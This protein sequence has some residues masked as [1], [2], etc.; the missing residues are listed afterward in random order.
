MT[1]ERVAALVAR[2][3]RTYTRGVPAPIR[4]RRAGEIAADLHDQITHER[5]QGTSD[6]R[7]AL[8][9]LSRMV[10]GVAADASWRSEHATATT[11]QSSTPEKPMNTDPTAHR[12]LIAIVLATVLLLAVPL[13]GMLVT[14]EV[15]WGPVDFAVAG[16]LILG[17]GLLLRA[18]A[19]KAGDLAYRA[20]AGVALGAAFLLVWTTLAVGIIG[21]PD[22]LANV[23]YVAVV[24]V[25]VLGAVSARFRPEGMARA[26]LATALVQALVAGIALI[27][28]EHEAPGASV[29]EI[30]ALNGFFAALFI[31]SAL[32]FR[33]AALK[34]PRIDAQPQR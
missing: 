20:A 4:Q 8:N 27:A 13:V 24:A 33:H 1:P 32:L 31:G 21:E 34:R 17:T 5:A 23:M 16:A 28:G 2:W 29:S 11:V 25:G 26:L 12:S 6:R 22:E 3:V 14:D 9:L 30:L 19:R 15:A 18:A 10:R 7:I